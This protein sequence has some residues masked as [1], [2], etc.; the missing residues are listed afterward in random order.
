MMKTPI[1]KLR[2]GRALKNLEAISNV[3]SFPGSKY[4]SS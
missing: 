3:S 2:L 4:G 1:S